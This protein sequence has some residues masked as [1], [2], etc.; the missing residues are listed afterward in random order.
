MEQIGKYEVLD[1]IGSG[2]FATVYKGY[3]P[4]IKR[5]VAIKV[6]SSREED[7]KQRFYREAEIAGSLVH[8]NITMVYDFGL[9]EGQPYLVEEYLSGEDLSYFIRRREPQDIPTRLDFLTQIARGLGH[10]HGQGVIHRDIKPSNIRVRSDGRLKIMDFGTAKL[11][12]AESQLTQSGMTLGTVAYLS[13]ERLL[14][15]RS[16]TN[17][18]LFSYGVMAYELM[19]FRRPFGGRNIPH[20]IEQVLS[21]PPIPLEDSWPECPPGLAEIVHRCLLKD[22]AERYASC[23]EIV[24]D[25]EG[26]RADLT[27]EVEAPAA[28][29]SRKRPTGAGPQTSVQVTSLMERAR[30]LM[31]RERHS[32]AEVLLEEVLEMSPES[33]EAKKLLLACRE[34]TAG[35]DPAGAPTPGAF[36]WEGPEER[37]ERKRAE[38]VASIALYIEKGEYASAIE[39]LSFAEKLFG[40]IAEAPKLRRLAVERV[41]DSV[42]RFRREGRDAGR[43]AAEALGTLR[44]QNRLEPEKERDL[45]ERILDLIPED[46]AA[47]GLRPVAGSA[48]AASRLSDTGAEGPPRQARLAEAISSI[49]QLLDR[50]DAR[51]AVE[52][53]DFA[54]KLYGEFDDAEALRSRIGR[55]LTLG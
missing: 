3:D 21:S 47:Q 26:V 48:E 50:G 41:R 44:R 52:A 14:G 9:H 8:R 45:T 10:A 22:P 7:G 24:R 32:R 20:L 36:S 18:D 37:R 15:K 29:A 49:E 16:G 53:L 11:A 33:V 40:S 25:L 2:G 31:G 55:A 38:A 42:I 5:P 13:P 17:S 1:Q 39:A 27:G 43:R 34:A 6:C 30:D 51:T 19:S 23:A 12:D 4:F 46:P 35:D 54:V 28:A